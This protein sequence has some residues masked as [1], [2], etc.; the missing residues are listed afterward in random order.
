MNFVFGIFS[1]NGELNFAVQSDTGITTDPER[2][3]DLFV[4]SLAKVQ[5]V[6]LNQPPGASST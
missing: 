1:L 2:I 5:E 3:L 4:E 6:A